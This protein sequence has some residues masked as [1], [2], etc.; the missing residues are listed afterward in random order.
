MPSRERSRS[1]W[2]RDNEPQNMATKAGALVVEGLSNLGGRTRESDRSSEGRRE[3]MEDVGGCWCRGAS[4]PSLCRF[5]S[6]NVDMSRINDLDD[7]KQWIAEHRGRIDTYWQH[8]H[9]FNDSMEARIHEVTS[10]LTAI[11]KKL[12]FVSGMAAALG[13]TIGT[14]I[15]RLMT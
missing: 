11:E 3:G 15:S 13:G 14:L 12:I 8:Q 10:R 5:E 9:R 4:H 6:R 1:I 7:V 2:R